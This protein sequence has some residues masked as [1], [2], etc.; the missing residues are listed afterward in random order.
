MVQNHQILIAQRR[1]G[2]GA[3][4]A[5]SEFHFI[6]SGSENLDDG[7]NLPAQQSFVRPVNYQGYDVKQADVGRHYSLARM[8]SAA[9]TRPMAGFLVQ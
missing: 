2:V 7:S 5:I 6:H 3:P 9:V 4:F 8:G 1:L